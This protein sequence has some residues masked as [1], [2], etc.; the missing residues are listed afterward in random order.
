MMKKVGSLL[1]AFIMC[2]MPFG[3]VFAYG[4]QLQEQEVDIGPLASVVGTILGA[5]KFV[6]YVVAI[7]MII[8]VG[9]KYLTAGAGEKAKIK[10]TLVPMLAGALL[11][12][13]GMT[14]VDW[15]WGL[16]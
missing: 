4:D 9:I 13:F 10:D 16:A 6:G 7:V 5:M 3:A 2:M 12:I 11:I 8:Y 14:L 1:L 15:I